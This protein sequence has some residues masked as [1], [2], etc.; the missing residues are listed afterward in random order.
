MIEKLHDLNVKKNKI[1][2]DLI[3]F[4]IGTLMSWFHIITW[5]H[6]SQLVV[7]L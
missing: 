2:N 7:N 4:S 3:G 5:K 1:Q 6:V